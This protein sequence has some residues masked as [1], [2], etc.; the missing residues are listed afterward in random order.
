MRREREEE[1]EKER[2][3][4][5]ERESISRVRKERK[6]TTGAEWLKRR[7]MAKRFFREKENTMLLPFSKKA[8]LL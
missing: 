2:E 3:K 8:T 6:P 5:K 4:E 7:K 1:R